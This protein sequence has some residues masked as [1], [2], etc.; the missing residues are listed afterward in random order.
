MSAVMPPPAP[1]SAPH[2]N[3]CVAA[4]HKSLEAEPEQ[5]VRPA[6]MIV[7][8]ERFVAVALPANKFVLLAYVAERSDDDALVRVVRPVKVLAPVKRDESAR[9]VDEAAVMVMF[10]EP[11]K[12]V[13]LMVR[14]VWSVV[15]V[16]ALP[17]ME[18]LIVVVKVWVPVKVLLV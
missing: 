15:A 5:E 4:F 14:G 16:L 1:A 10:A 6:P 9:R 11:S 7:E 17:E 3:C 8:S 18:P 12:E 2:S 13:P